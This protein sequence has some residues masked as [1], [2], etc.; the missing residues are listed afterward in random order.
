MVVALSYAWHI[1]PAEVEQLPADMIHA[2]G[3]FLTEMYERSK[4]R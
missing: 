2:M 4:R 1:S 3:V